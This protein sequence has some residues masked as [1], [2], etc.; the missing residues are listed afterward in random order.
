MQK[1]KNQDAYQLEKKSQIAQ[2]YSFLSVKS[3]ELYLIV[4][5]IISITL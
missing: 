2:Y 3:L 5:V 1:R 4:A